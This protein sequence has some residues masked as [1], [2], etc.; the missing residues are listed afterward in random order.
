MRSTQIIRVLNLDAIT[1]CVTQNYLQNI[2][3]HY[4]RDLIGAVSKIQIFKRQFFKI[5]C[6]L[7]S[8]QP[9]EGCNFEGLKKKQDRELLNFEK[10]DVNNHY[11]SP[12]DRFNELDTGSHRETFLALTSAIS[13]CHRCSITRACYAS[14]LLRVYLKTRYIENFLIAR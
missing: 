13:V 4:V 14:I 3:L 8:V 7:R 11:Q 6:D 10:E 2:M 9:K 1:F 5:E 12:Q